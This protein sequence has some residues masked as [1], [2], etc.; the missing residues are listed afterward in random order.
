[1]DTATQ[2]CD[3]LGDLN[4]IGLPCPLIIYYWLNGATGNIL[5]RRVL[6]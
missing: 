3:G 5:E 6:L 4:A 2:L 1:M